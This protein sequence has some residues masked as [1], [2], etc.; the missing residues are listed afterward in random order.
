[1]EAVEL[2]LKHNKDLTPMIDA[3]DKAERSLKA[4]REINEK[5]EAEI[6]HLE[7]R[8]ER[9][10]A[11]IERLAKHNT[12]LDD[13]R[14]F[15]ISQRNKFKQKFE[16]AVQTNEKLIADVREMQSSG[17]FARASKLKRFSTVKY[18]IQTEEDNEKSA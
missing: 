14:K 7:A 4:S 8:A 17:V 9:E 2:H 12:E 15:L 13:M 3:R 11:Q 18:V 16:E 5:L 6:A 1:M 10:T